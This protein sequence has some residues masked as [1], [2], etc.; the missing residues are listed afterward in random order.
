MSRYIELG[1]MVC[2]DCGHE[3][4]DDIRLQ[5]HHK[6]NDRGNNSSGNLVVLCSQCHKELHHP[7]YKQRRGDVVRLRSLGYTYQ[8]IGDM[9]GVTRQRAQQIFAASRT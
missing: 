1:L 7:G 2:E 5:K 6:D 8:S 3:F 9:L 4:T